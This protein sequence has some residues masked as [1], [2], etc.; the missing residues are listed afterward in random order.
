MIT[1]IIT[2]PG[3]KTSQTLSRL[4]V[5]SSIIALGPDSLSE[6]LKDVSTNLVLITDG[7]NR[8]REGIPKHSMKEALEEKTVVCP[9]YGWGDK[10]Y[11]PS[12]VTLV[13]ETPSGRFMSSRWKSKSQHSDEPHN[14]PSAMGCILT[15]PRWL[16]SMKEAWEPFSGTNFELC[17]SIL[18]WMRGGRCR[19]TPD[20]RVVRKLDKAPKEPKD[21]DERGLM[22]HALFPPKMLKEAFLR[23]EG[24]PTVPAIPKGDLKS[25]IRMKSKIE[26]ITVKSLEQVAERTRMEVSHGM[27][28]S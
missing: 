10:V 25:F 13:P 18:T 14:V 3:N 27:G 26:D 24:F 1:A 2:N 19:L 28:S 11:Q 23:V 21:M 6:I 20:W 4:E 8:F 17:V 22:A 9:S 16:N 12:V 5:V 15:S 7:R